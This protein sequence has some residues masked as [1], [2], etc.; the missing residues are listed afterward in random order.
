MIKEI[1]RNFSPNGIRTASNFLVHFTGC[2]NEERTS[3]SLLFETLLGNDSLPMKE[4]NSVFKSCTVDWS[5]KLRVCQ[6]GSSNFQAASLDPPLITNFIHLTKN[7][8]LLKFSFLAAL[9]AVDCM[10]L[11]NYSSEWNSLSGLYNV[12]STWRHIDE[13]KVRVCQQATDSDGRRADCADDWVSPDWYSENRFMVIIGR[14]EGPFVAR[15]VNFQQSADCVGT[16][17]QL[18][19][20]Y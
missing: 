11:V 18:E 10:V 12:G 9:W 17:S 1:R 2:S 5:L 20:L 3:E 8:F 6:C 16:G 4:E 15:Y 7:I 14:G 13:G 19:T